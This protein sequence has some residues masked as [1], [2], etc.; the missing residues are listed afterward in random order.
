[1][2][3]TPQFCMKSFQ[4][5][6]QMSVLMSCMFFLKK[7]ISFRIRCWKLRMNMSTF[8][9]FENFGLWLLNYFTWCWFVWIVSD[10]HV[11]NGIVVITVEFRRRHRVLMRSYWAFSFSQVYSSDRKL[12]VF[13]DDALFSM[14]GIHIC[15]EKLKVI[16]N[17]IYQ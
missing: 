15:S 8:W 7:L 12:P 16:L 4:L 1:M 17:N 11:P 3:T 9:C 14:V 6:W 13:V 5:W 10:W 2:T